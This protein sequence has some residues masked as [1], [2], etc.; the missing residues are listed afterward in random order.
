MQ[1][2][3]CNCQLEDGGQQRVGGPRG[4]AEDETEIGAF[5]FTTNYCT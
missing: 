1:C 2:V 3:Q 5:A 4:S